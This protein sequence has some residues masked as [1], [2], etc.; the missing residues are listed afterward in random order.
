ML[1]REEMIKVAREMPNVR[2]LTENQNAVERVAVAALDP[3]RICLN[4]TAEEWL[5]VAG[6]TR[7]EILRRMGN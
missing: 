4:H 5:V 2:L 1:T 7:D 6:V 3:D